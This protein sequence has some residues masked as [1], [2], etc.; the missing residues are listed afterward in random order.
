MKTMLKISLMLNVGLFASLMFI[1]IIVTHR[2]E[3]AAATP[4]SSAAKAA[5]PVLSAGA[6]AQTTQIATSV[7]SAPFNWKQLYAP[8][9]RDYVRN[10]RAV[11]CPEATVRAIVAADVYAAY[12]VRA[13]EI[14]KEL[15]DFENS[16]WTNQIAAFREETAMKDELRGMPDAEAAEIADLLGLKP[17]PVQVAAAA[18][19]A[20]QP[21]RRVH[22]SPHITP[23]SQPLVLQDVDLSALNLTEDQ[24]QAIANLRQN[25][26]QQIGGANQDP[27]D[28]AYLA[29][30]QQAQPAA[31]DLLKAYLGGDAYTEY[32]VL[33][34]QKAVADEYRAQ[35]QH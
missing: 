7:E 13:N 15:S 21:S 9:Y 32:G 34:A 25:F 33:A 31:D 3:S 14:E 26:L 22:V 4:S 30:W 20:A 11:G 19:T 23:V 1:Y 28:P 10:L 27:N 6:L 2:K 12:S 8:D 29:R 16:S 18:E 17:A 35:Q 5:R 24:K